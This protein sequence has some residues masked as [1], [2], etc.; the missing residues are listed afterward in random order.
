M[1]QVAVLAG[2]R[3]GVHVGVHE[4]HDD[5]TLVFSR[6]RRTYLK[7]MLLPRG[8]AQ[9][10]HIVPYPNHV[11]E[12][13]KEARRQQVY[14]SWWNGIVLGYPESFV[15]SY[16]NGM[17]VDLTDAEKRTVMNLAKNELAYKVK[18]DLDRPNLP[19]IQIGYD[20]EVPAEVWGYLG[21]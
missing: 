20:H 4:Y 1:I 5:R 16:C 17:H 3:L 18:M 12:G 9:A 6:S 19:P 10:L 7:N 8:E 14:N 15:R 21:V 2:A 11:T 13:T